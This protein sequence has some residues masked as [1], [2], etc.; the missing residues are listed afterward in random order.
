MLIA[1][2]SGHAEAQAMLGAWLLVP[3]LSGVTSDPGEALDWLERAAGQNQ[4]QAMHYLGMFYMEYG[5]RTGLQDP[6]RAV[7]LLGRCAELTTHPDCAFAYGLALESGIGTERDLVRA[8]AFYGIAVN[9]DP[10]G[11]S[12]ARRAALKEQLSASELAKANA[13][14]S[15]VWGQYSAQMK[16]DRA[17]M[18]NCRFRSPQPC[19]E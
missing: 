3:Y 13:L 15:Q 19:K 14:S 4:P 11:K 18:L 2:K 17:Q 10:L 12:G 16:R 9:R 1:A 7:G 8:Y 5:S 6:A